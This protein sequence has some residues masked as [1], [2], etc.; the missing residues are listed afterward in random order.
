MLA[1]CPTQVVFLGSA[2]SSRLKVTLFGAS[3][4]VVVVVVVV[5]VVIVVVETW[6]LGPLEKG[7]PSKR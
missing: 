1:C 7:F 6:R 5:V 4:L 3:V 2:F